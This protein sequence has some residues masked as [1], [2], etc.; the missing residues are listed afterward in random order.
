MLA[1]LCALRG[2]V[3]L[4]QGEELGL[5]EIDL[6]RDQLRDPV[7]DLYY[8]LFKGR[9][10]C[11]TPMPW[12]A[13]KPNLGFSSG[14]PW[15]PP[16]PDHAALAV[17]AQERDPA[18]HSLLRAPR[19]PSAKHMR[20]CG[21]PISLCWTR[22]C[23]LAFKRGEYAVRLQSGTARG[24]LGRA[25]RR[26]VAWFWNWRGQ[27]VGPKFEPWPVKCL[28]RPPLKRRAPLPTAAARIGAAPYGRQRRRIRHRPETARPARGRR[29]ALP[30]CFRS[31]F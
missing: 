5:P 31:I 17:A 16:G 21:T 1:L 14:T 24:E 25:K 23:L 20:I 19:C 30:R 2:T 8:P 18:R 22:R 3:L 13:A 11:R 12:D 15:L 7:G 6:R 4:Y 29:T 10:G 27:I 28:V 9:D 26:V